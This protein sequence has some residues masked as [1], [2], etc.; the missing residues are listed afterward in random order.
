LAL[1]LQAIDEDFDRSP[2]NQGTGSFLALEQLRVPATLQWFSPTGISAA[3]RVTYLRQ[4]GIFCAAG[5]LVCDLADS[6]ETTTADVSLSYRL[7]RRAGSVALDVL[8]IF[9]EEFR[10]QSIDTS[11]LVPFTGRAVFARA[12]LTF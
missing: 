12:S 9:D 11:Q 8:N 7:P 3:L 1:S 6:E 5:A 2:D 10:Y 4:E